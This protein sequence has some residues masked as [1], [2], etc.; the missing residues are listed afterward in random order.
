MTGAPAPPSRD[1]RPVVAAVWTRKLDGEPMAGRLRIA[2]AV[3]AALER[4]ARLVN[5][6]VPSLLG[7]P[8]PRRFLEAGLAFL[9]GLLRGR[10]LPLQCA[11]FAAASDAA[12]LVR[13]IPA[14]ARVVY[15]DGVRCHSLLRRLR[16][17]RPDLRVVVDFDDLMSRRMQLL[18]SAREPLSPGYLTQRLP[19]PLRRLATHPRTGRLIVFYEGAALRGVEREFMAL[20]DV[21][22]LLS[23]EDARALEADVAGV[24]APLHAQV[25]V[26]PPPTPSAQD[27]RPF[28]GGPVR[29]V[30]VGADALTQN[31]LTIDYLFDLW[32]R[33]RI[34]TP[35]AIYGLQTRGVT[36]PPQVS[37]CGY[38]DALTDIYD[39]RSVLLTPSFLGGGIKTK[40]LEA[41][42]HGAPVI[43]NAR[44]FESID[45]PGYPLLLD[46]PALLEIVRAPDDHLDLLRRA[47][48]EGAAYVRRAHDPERFAALWRDAVLPP[49]H[50]LD[51]HAA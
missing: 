26:I 24:H 2:Q 47:A 12:R 14:D 40:V 43:A 4:Q 17:E 1:E 33:E 19:G 48:A 20:A 10:P 35:L 45:A 49:R 51:V 23:S 32:R 18:L 46:E 6:E 22:T 42:A 13:E 34:T 41:F 25:R 8:S 50:V 44:T 31:R 21:V 11:L 39:G 37:L 3:R 7:S 36:P 30:F 28:G 16:R 29:M 15:L 9:G 5:L 38:A 27:P